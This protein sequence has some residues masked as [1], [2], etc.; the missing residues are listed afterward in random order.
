[1]MDQ[2]TQT[3]RCSKCGTDRDYSWFSRDRKRKDWRTA[4]CKQC[5]RAAQRQRTIGI[6]QDQFDAMLR[7]QE[8]RCGICRT[9]FETDRETPDRAALPRIDRSSD[10]TVR[11]LL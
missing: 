2:L 3:K 11:G 10:G 1:I 9:A 7:Q 6:S 4:W 8:G 5:M